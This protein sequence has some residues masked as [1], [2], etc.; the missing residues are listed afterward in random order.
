[1]QVKQRFEGG[2]TPATVPVRRDRSFIVDITNPALIGSKGE[3]VS[4]AGRKT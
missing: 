2:W 3:L 1:M 4:E